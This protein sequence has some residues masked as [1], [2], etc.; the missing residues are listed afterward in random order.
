MERHISAYHWVI[1]NPCFY[2]AG[3]A[4]AIGNEPVYFQNKIIGV[5]TSGGYGFRVNKSLSF[6]YVKAELAEKESEFEIE[7]QGKKRKAKVLKEM[8]Y[9]PANARLMSWWFLKII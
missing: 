2:A 7:I 3:N 9:D 1:D 6:A 5:T 8:A 4:D